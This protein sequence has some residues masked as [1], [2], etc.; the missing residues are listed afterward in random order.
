MIM[1]NKGYLINTQ[2][3][4]LVKSEGKFAV[5]NKAVRLYALMT[6]P[7][8][9]VAI[10]QWVGEPD[11]GDYTDLYRDGNQV[12]LTQDNNQHV[13]VVEARYK[14]HASA[15]FAGT[16]VVYFETSDL[17]LDKNVEYEVNA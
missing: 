8:D 14:V 7:A 1:D 5:A 11:L 3:P 17:G 16:V 12:T 13:E 15:P 2:N 6:N 4:A 10:Q 9:V